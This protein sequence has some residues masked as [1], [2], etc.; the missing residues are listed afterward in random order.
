MPRLVRRRPLPERIK[1]WLDPY[2]FLL[3]LSEEFDS[4]DWEQWQKQWSTTIG[5][6]LNIAF[7][8]AR[9]RSGSRSR[10]R[11]DD[12]FGEDESYAGFTAWLVCSLVVCKQSWAS[13]QLQAT[14]VVHTLS[15]LAIA[16]AIYTFY[17]RRHYR[18]FESSIDAAPST[19]S[20]YR[21]RVNSSPLSSSPLRFLSS[22][23]AAD[24][25]ES[26]SHPDAARDVWELA[27]WDPTPLS[28]RLFCLFSPAHIFL[29]CLFLPTAVTD[30]RPSTTVVT[31]V[32]LSAL[33][34]TQLTILQ[35]NFSQQSKDSTVVH[36]EV[37]NEYDAKFVHPRTRPL[38]RDVGIQYSAPRPS[39][40]VH[41]TPTDSDANIVETHTPAVVINKGFHT[42]PNP[43]YAGLVDP[44]ASRATPS[45]GYS[46]DINASVQTPIYSHALS[47]PFKPTTAI[48][49]PQFKPNGAVRTGD[50]GNLGVYSHA[51]SPLRKSASTDFGEGRYRYRSDSPAKREGSPLKRSSLAPGTS[52]GQRLG[53]LSSNAGR[54]DHSER[55]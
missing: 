21:V 45:R 4:S 30:P 14:F 26:R 17:R 29:Y 24:P 15:L 10:R 35:W 20:A 40:S 38:V 5:V 6:A 2:D 31:T 37:L 54:K 50:G 48:R 42:R 55:F 52:S 46:N 11:G 13:E 41:P 43:N 25:A 12:V 9:A 23:L 39:H 34:S 27:V 44:D 49:Q 19:P 22:M 53:H 36:K 3:W 1:A 51:N 33:L 47:S 7:L 32:V 28:L 16:N 18:L 8:I